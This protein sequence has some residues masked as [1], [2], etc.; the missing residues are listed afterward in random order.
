RTALTPSDQRAPMI[1]WNPCP[2]SRGIRAHLAVE[3]VPAIAWNSQILLGIAL[4]FVLVPAYFK[5]TE[6]WFGWGF[7]LSL[8]VLLALWLILRDLGQA[9]IC[10]IAFYGMWRGWGWEWWQAGL[11]AFPGVALTLAFMIGGG[12][13]SAVGSMARGRQ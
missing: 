2:P 1:P 9:I 5:G 8:G 4:L 11:V 7:G 12:V 13:V 3:F 10:G 6:T